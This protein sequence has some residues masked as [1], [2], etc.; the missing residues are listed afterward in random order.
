MKFSNVTKA[1]STLFILFA[2]SAN[3]QNANKY[4][5]TI[6]NGADTP[7][8][9][10][11]FYAKNGA[12][13]AA[14]V[15]EAPT[16]GF[17]QLCQTG[18]PATR[19]TELKADSAVQFAD[20]TTAPI[21]PGESRSV[22]VEVMNPQT[23]SIHLEVMYGKSKNVCGVASV[24]S[25]SLVALKEHVTQEYLGKDNTLLTGAF[26]DPA[27]PTGSN[28]QDTNLC[29]DA[30][31]AI[32]CLRQLSVPNPES[33]KIRNFAGYF[34]SLLMALEVKFGAADLQT[35]LIPTSGAVQIKLKL[36]H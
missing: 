24:N 8:S 33:A 1:I 25:H 34:P 17:I 26:L 9:P 10:G 14:Q 18:N 30:V 23:Q 12:S 7:I 31:N 15:G 32:A 21:L 27:L 6:T 3:A 22:E 28:Y 20:Q 13:P 4:E 16:V 5:L 19:L 35:L 2:V 11:V 36:K 29:P